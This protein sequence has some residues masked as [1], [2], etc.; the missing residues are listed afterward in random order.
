[1]M[2]L[3]MVKVG[4]LSTTNDMLDEK[5]GKFGTKS[6]AEFDY[7]TLAWYYGNLIDRPI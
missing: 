3:D 6:R 2:K 4:Q 5:Y 7:K 1:M